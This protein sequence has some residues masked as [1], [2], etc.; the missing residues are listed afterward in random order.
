MAENVKET[1]IY[2]Q[3]CFWFIHILN[4]KIIDEFSKTWKKN[5]VSKKNQITV[6]YIFNTFIIKD[7]LYYIRYD[8]LRNESFY[9]PHDK[10]IYARIKKKQKYIYIYHLMLYPNIDWRKL[11]YNLAFFSLTKVSNRNAVRNRQKSRVLHKKYNFDFSQGWAFYVFFLFSFYLTSKLILK[12]TRKNW[13][14]TPF[15]IWFRPKQLC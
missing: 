10:I 2:S 13:L 1:S 9:S 5:Q 6:S 14:Q 11:W 8:F 12:S 7:F 15:Y 3:I 4:Q